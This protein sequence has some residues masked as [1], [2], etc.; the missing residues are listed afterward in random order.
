MGPTRHDLQSDVAGNH[1]GDAQ[2][3]R[4]DRRSRPAGCGVIFITGLDVFGEDIE[5]S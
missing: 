1:R 3:L 2:G 5:P 4:A